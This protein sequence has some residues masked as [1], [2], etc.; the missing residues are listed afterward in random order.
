MSPQLCRV[1]PCYFSQPFYKALALPAA[2]PCSSYKYQPPRFSGF[3][4]LRRHPS[5][6]EG[7]DL[8]LQSSDIDAQ[9]SKKLPFCG[10]VAMCS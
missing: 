9:L 3:A 5:R 7:A 8:Y 2:A 10:S 1:K 4:P 6:S